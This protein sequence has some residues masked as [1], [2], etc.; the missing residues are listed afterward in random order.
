MP[1][2]CAG[3]KQEATARNISANTR[4]DFIA[5]SRFGI[6]DQISNRHAIAGIHL[7]ALVR[8]LTPFFELKPKPWNGRLESRP[9]PADKN[10]RATWR[11]LSSLRVRGTFQFP[12]ENSV[13]MRSPYYQG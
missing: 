5:Y 9:E 12:V 4:R 13:K 3:S 7:P 2:P 11:R 8:I 10:V 1:A 6:I